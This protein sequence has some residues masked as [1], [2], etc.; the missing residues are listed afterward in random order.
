MLKILQARLQQY[1]N[2]ELPD[3]QAGFRKGRGTRDQ[4]ANI[5]WITEKAREFQT[6]IYFC[7]IDYAK[8]SDCVDHNKLWKILKEMEK[9]DH[10]TCLL[11]NLYAGQEATVRTGHGTTDWFQI[12]RGVL[13]QGC[14]LS[15][16]LFNLYAEYIM[17]NAWLDKAQAGIKIARRN[18][19]NLR[20]KDDTTLMAES[21]KE[22]KSLLMKVKEES[23]KVGLKLNIQKTKIMTSGPITS[24]QTDGETIE[25]VR[26]FILGGS[27]ISADG[28]CSHEIKRCLL[29][30]RKAM[31]NLDSILNSRDITLSTKVHLVKTM[32]FPVVMYGCASWTIKKAEHQRIDAFEL[33]CWRRFL[34]VPWTARRS[35][36]SILME[37]SPEYS[38]EGLRLKLQYFGH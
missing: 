21:K 35:N 10:L 14:I 30:G 3:V 8:S 37:I 17:R 28:D 15:P 26:N 19:T 31:T 16:W 6:S 1:V 11:R 20:Y 18:I 29:L 12:K 22:L 23:E 33:W 27:K 7:F 9:P 38:L 24:W 34:R 25:T 2:C 5:C 32:V 4:I 13:R 36:Q